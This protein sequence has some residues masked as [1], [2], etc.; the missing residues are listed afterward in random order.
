MNVSIVIRTYNEQRHLRELLE[1]IQSQL[2]PEGMTIETVIVDSGS[3]DDTLTIAA[4]FPTRVVPIKKEDFSFGRSLNVG[5]AAAQGDALVFV[6]GHCIPTGPRWIADLVAPLGKNNVAYTYGGQ[7]G[8]DDSHFSEK[9][10][11]GKYF[12]AV[13]KVPQ[14]GFYCNNANAAMLKS[15]WA[16]HPFDEELTGLEDMHL[17]KRLVAQGY[18]LAYVAEAAVYHLHSESWAQVRRRFER[19]A[20]ALQHIM[21][22]VH[23]NRRDVARYFMSAVFLDLGA[24]LQQRCLRQNLKHIL[25][26]RFM[27]F[28]G[29][30][31]GNHFHRM[32]SQELKESY[33]YPR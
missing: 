28:T 19:E 24:A 13:S 21:P 32:M 26:Y 30:F 8:N 18:K 20:I 7:V 15:V 10:I 16:A 23:L 12:P 11:F 6:S 4:Q 1:G 25:L 5:C 3:T 22:E 27:Q 14:E 9:Q 31:R 17:A 29:S 33:F 2:C